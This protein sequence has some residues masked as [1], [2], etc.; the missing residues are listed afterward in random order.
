MK[1]DAHFTLAR[2]LVDPHPDLAHIAL[3]YSLMLADVTPPAYSNTTSWWD[4][5]DLLKDRSVLPSNGPNQA[6]VLKGLIT[7]I[8]SREKYKHGYGASLR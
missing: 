7:F 8:N 3:T 4:L 1:P 5:L 2:V 6:V